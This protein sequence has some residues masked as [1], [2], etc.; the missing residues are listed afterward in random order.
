MAKLTVADITSGYTSTTALNTAFTAIETALENTLSR[1]GTSP[2]QMSSNLDMNGYAILNAR[3]TSGNENFIW[4]GTWVV[5][6]AYAVN[7]LVYAPEGSNEGATLICVTAHTAGATLD[8]DAANW[9]VFAQRGIPGASGGDVTGPASSTLNS[10]ARFSD[11]SGKVL[12][13]GAVIGTDVQA[14][15]ANL[16]AL[17]AF[18]TD[19]DGTLAANSDVKIATQKATKTYV[20]NVVVSAT[21]AAPDTATDYFLFEDATDNTQKKALLSSLGALTLS[22]AQA[23]TSGTTKDFTIPIVPKR[24]TVMLNEV[25]HNGTSVLLVQLGTGGTPTTTGYKSF[26]EGMD[27]ATMTAV[28]QTTGFGLH[29]AGVAAQAYT[30]QLIFTHMGSNTWVMSGAGVLTGD[31]R[32]GSTCGGGVTLAGTLNFLR[33]TSVGGNTF[34]GGSIN[35]AYE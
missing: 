8:G 18:T 21:T 3:A 26:G 25:S 5:G 7:N 29:D 16:A 6:T 2:N 34:D 32:E 15:H 12:K 9:A 22:T 19:T 10:L 13:D 35:I 33:L 31:V 14:Y 23:T 30:G 20:D 17:T 24:V 11:V 1:D 28:H 27:G 4:M